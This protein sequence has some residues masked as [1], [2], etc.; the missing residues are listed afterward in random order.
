MRFWEKLRFSLGT[1]A[2]PLRAS[3]RCLLGSIRAKPRSDRPSRLLPSRDI[4]IT[5]SGLSLS[6]GATLKLCRWFPA[7]G[8]ERIVRGR[9]GAAGDQSKALPVGPPGG[10][11]GRPA[12]RPGS[13]EGR[14]PGMAW[15]DARQR[16][17]EPAARCGVHQ[18]DTRGKIHLV[19]GS[20]RPGLVDQHAFGL[21][22]GM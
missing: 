4:S 16:I 22:I 11:I 19:L 9:G 14:K 1:L 20:A 18:R 2:P 3:S 8:P 7:P 10:S 12:G 13:A 17:L 15:M 5:S 21:E 6:V